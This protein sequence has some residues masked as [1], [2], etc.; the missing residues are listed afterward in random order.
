M[1]TSSVSSPSQAHC[2]TIQGKSRET[3]MYE[4][5]WRQMHYR[6]FIFACI[7]GRI[8]THTHFQY[9]HIIVTSQSPNVC[10]SEPLHQCDSTAWWRQQREVHGHSELYHCHHHGHYHHWPVRAI[11]HAMS[12]Q[13]PQ[14]QVEPAS[15]W[16]A[17]NA[18]PLPGVAGV[19]QLPHPQVVINGSSEA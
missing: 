19:E 4:Y 10:V 7:C 9:M 15:L 2:R 17:D 13:T 5:V 16:P 1:T 3:N 6:L 18:D 12:F 11:S 8:C 14:Y